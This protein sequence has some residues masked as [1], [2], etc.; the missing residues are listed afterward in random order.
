MGDV[1]FHRVFPLPLLWL[2]VALG[3]A[4]PT[5]RADAQASHGLSLAC[6]VEDNQIPPSTNGPIWLT[7]TVKAEG[8]STFSGGFFDL[9]NWGVIATALPVT[10]AKMQSCLDRTKTDVLVPLFTLNAGGTKVFHVLLN[11]L[12]PVSKQGNRSG[13]VILPLEDMGSTRPEGFTLVAPFSVN[14]GPPLSHDQLSAITDQLI[15]PVETYNVENRQDALRSISLL[16]D[17]CAIPLLSRAIRDRQSAAHS[18]LKQI[19][20]AT[21]E[22]S[23]C[24]N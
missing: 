3:L 7:I 20:K 1:R 21:Y 2:F 14:V 16:P 18:R 22:K 23:R 12:V 5:L 8:T 11:D 13:W 15:G 19:D 4:Y 10:A 6:N 17:K 9:S 24:S